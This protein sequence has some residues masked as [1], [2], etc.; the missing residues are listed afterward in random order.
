ML[1]VFLHAR[2]LSPSQVQQQDLIYWKPSG[3]SLIM[4]QFR[5]RKHKFV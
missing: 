1:S 5:P 4:L 3:K 2:I